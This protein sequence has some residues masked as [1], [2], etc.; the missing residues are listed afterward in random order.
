MNS[1]VGVAL[2]GLLLTGPVVSR[3]LEERIEIF[4]LAIGLLAMT[5]AGAWRWDVAVHAA[6]VPLG[7]TF[8]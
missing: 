1:L 8:T 3:A 2:I 4:F 5:L 7:V 6:L